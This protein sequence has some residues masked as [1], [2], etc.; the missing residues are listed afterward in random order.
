MPFHIVLVHPEIPANTGNIARTCAATG[1]HLH[2]VRPLGFS[3]DDRELKRAGLD[4]WYA[5]NITYYDSFEEVQAA[6]PSARFF[7]TSTRSKRRYSDFEFRDGDFFVFGK[8]TKGLPQEL[9][10]RHPD[11]CMRLPMTDKVRSLNLANTAAILVYEALKQTGF[12]G[13][14]VPAGE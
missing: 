14:D 12:P 10:D 1:T 4:Y 5:V 11:T 6:H 7:F 9:L 13:L 8:E 2:L 3:T